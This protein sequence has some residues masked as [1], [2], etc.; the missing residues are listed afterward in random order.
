MTPRWRL[1]RSTGFTAVG[2]ALLGMASNAPDAVG[3]V[4][5]LVV[6]AWCLRA[7][8]VVLGPAVVVAPEAL[9]VIRSWPW[10]RRLAW[11]EVEGVEVV[12][13]PWVL[14]LELVDGAV[15]ELP[16]VERLD[17]LYAA[18]EARR[19]GARG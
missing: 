2:L 5:A 9:V 12:P 18:V 16:P 1:V 14:R 4:L 8:R 11:S 17:D 19:R 3:V 13:G 10:R 7:L 6:V 15:L